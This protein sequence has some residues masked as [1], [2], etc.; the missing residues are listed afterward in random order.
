MKENILT[1]LQMRELFHIE[2]LRWFSRKVKSAHYAV[3]GG[4]NIRLFFGSVRYSEDMDL[5]VSGVSVHA[6]KDTVTLILNTP[7]FTESLR[8]FGIKGV[9]PP[10]MAKA[11]QT[12]TTQRFK[13]HLLT[14]AGED[15]FTKVEFSRRGFGGKVI[16]E[17]VPDLI[18]RP[19][20]LAPL[21]VPHYDAGSAITQK[22]SALGLRTVLQ[23]R[24]IFD[25]FV[26]HSQIAQTSGLLGVIS[27]DLLKKARERVFEVKFELFRDSVVEYLS[28]DDQNSYSNASAWEEVKLTVAQ[29]LEGVRTHA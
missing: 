18:L 9:V 19:Y 8:P 13:V 20:K 1:P 17:S 29:F 6:L 16:V 24:D 21:L 5:D 10:D 23:A 14:A 3:K 11:K 26:L 2:F 12:D 7:S 15:L 27:N 22:I 4:V 25:L 28:L